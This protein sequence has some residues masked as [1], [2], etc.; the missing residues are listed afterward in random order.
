ML[1]A[2]GLDEEHMEKVVGLR[3]PGLLS[4]KEIEAAC[5]KVIAL[6]ATMK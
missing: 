3:A 4:D 5:K 6:S 1:F 2:Y